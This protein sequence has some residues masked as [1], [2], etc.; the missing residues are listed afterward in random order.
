M[1]IARDEN[2]ELYLYNYRPRRYDKYF[3]V[4]RAG[5][6]NGVTA[7]KLDGSMF[8]EVTWWNSP[9]EVTIKTKKQ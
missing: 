6:T 5:V 7:M 8:Q 4:F 2:G 1:W 3:G 9:R